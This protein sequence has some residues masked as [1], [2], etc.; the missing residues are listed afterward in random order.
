MNIDLEEIE[1]R[2]LLQQL[3]FFAQM[4]VFSTW[5]HS[6]LQKMFLQ[7]SLESYTRNQIVY[8]QNARPTHVY[9]IKSGEFQVVNAKSN[10]MVTSCQVIRRVELPVKGGIEGQYTQNK[11]L[12]H[13]P[14]KNIRDVEVCIPI[15]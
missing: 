12:R 6:L 9:M 1:E 4:K 15:K 5:S 10:P 8:Y 11:L 7:T 14:K 2:K 13:K 3:N